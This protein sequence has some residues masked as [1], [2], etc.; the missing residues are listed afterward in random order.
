MAI[1]DGG[2]INEVAAMLWA[3]SHTAGFS[4]RGCLGRMDGGRMGC[5]AGGMLDGMLEQVIGPDRADG[6]I[7][8]HSAASQAVPVRG[9][10]S[11]KST[12][13]SHEAKKAFAAIG[14]LG[15]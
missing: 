4:A 11:S 10:P 15:P 6:P 3:R 8:P 9:S 5:D 12:N 7:S 13:E 14:A 1:V 2:G